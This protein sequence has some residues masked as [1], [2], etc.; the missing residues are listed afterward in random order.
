MKD[1]VG[2]SISLMFIAVFILLIAGYLALSLNYNK[3]FRA[4][5]K[6]IKIL[7]QNETWDADVQSKIS[8]GLNELR[9]PSYNNL[10]ING[11]GW[12]CQRGYCVKWIKDDKN[13]EKNS[14][15][16]KVVTATKID[17]PGIDR[18][19]RSLDFFQVSG[20]TIKLYPPE[21]IKTG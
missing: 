12:S 1:A 3:A 7:E 17:I 2:G 15:Y 13:Q 9:Y 20:D 19:M 14:G 11:D 5:N 21:E 10:D 18:L 4:K 6:I 8:D 16:F